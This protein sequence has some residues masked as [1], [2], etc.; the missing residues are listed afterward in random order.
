MKL[1]SGILEQYVQR[2]ACDFILRFS[3]F[4]QQK[5]ASDDIGG[6]LTKKSE[7]QNTINHKHIE[8]IKEV[9]SNSKR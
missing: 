7:T 5:R 4:K 8:Q 1:Y 3:E 6:K 9:L 2:I